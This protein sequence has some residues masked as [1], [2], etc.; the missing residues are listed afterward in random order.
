MVFGFYPAKISI[1]LLPSLYFQ[2]Q[3]LTTAVEATSSGKQLVL[4]KF[5][6]Q[7][8]RFLKQICDLSYG[9]DREELWIVTNV[10]FQ[11]WMECPAFIAKDLEFRHRNLI[12]DVFGG[13]FLQR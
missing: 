4:T 7:S 13:Q 6:N 12:S 5:L 8:Q 1:I 3:A 11:C 2:L 10:L 9:L